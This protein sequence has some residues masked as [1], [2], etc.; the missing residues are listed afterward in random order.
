MSVLKPEA[1]E[2]AL[3]VRTVTVFAPGM[4]D[5]EVIDILHIAASK[6]HFNRHVGAMAEGIEI[7]EQFNF[8]NR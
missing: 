6:D 7:I 3:R 8:G 2:V 5:D 4:K 1:D